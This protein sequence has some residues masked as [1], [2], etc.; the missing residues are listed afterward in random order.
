M[1]SVSSSQADQLSLG[2]L[3]RHT[4]WTLL[5]AGSCSDALHLIRSFP[6]PVVICDSTLPDGEWRDLL[7]QAVLSTSVPPLLIVAS[8]LADDRLWAEVMDAGGYDVLE[9]PFN[10]SEVVRV[11]SLAWLQWKNQL[12]AGKRRTAGEY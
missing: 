4:K 6:V 5:E 1:L 9:K 10:H 8:R 11:V 3:F 7:D 2:H 12:R